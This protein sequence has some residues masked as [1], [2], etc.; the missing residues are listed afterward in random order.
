MIKIDHRDSRYFI[1]DEEGT[2]STLLAVCEDEPTAQEIAEVFI[3]R[4]LVERM[5]E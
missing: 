4:R 2:S 3:R 1:T 5:G